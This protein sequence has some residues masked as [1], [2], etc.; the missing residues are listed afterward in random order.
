MYTN[1]YYAHKSPIT[2]KTFV[3]DLRA[4]QITYEFACENLSLEFVPTEQKYVQSWLTSTTGH[5]ECLLDKEIA[6]AGYAVA[7]IDLSNGQ[8]SSGRAYVIVAVHTTEPN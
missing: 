6:R 8:A 1:S 5:R 7:E 3:D 4:S 2:E